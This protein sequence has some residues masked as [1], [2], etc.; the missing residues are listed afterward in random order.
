MVPASADILTP[1]SRIVAIV[2]PSP[3]PAASPPFGGAGFPSATPTPK[4]Y[5]VVRGGRLQLSLTGSLSLGTQASSQT[6]Y[7]GTP[8]FTPTPNASGSPSPFIGTATTSN[9]AQSQGSLGM[10][11]DISRR[12]ATTSTDLRVPFAVSTN[13]RSLIGGTQLL[14]STPRYALGYGAQSTSLFGQL[15]AGS[16]LRSLYAI[17][18]TRNGDVTMYGGPSLGANGEELPLKGLRWRQ[19]AGP[20]LFEAGLVNGDGPQT[21]KATTILGGVATSRGPLSF[22]GESAWQD[23][24][25]GDEDVSGL[26]Y[27]LRADDGSM[28]SY[29]TLITRRI[30]PG[31][32]NFGVGENFGDNYWDVN[33][34]RAGSSQNFTADTSSE[35]VLDGVGFAS[36]L[37][38]SSLGYSGPFRFGSYSLT[39]QSQRTSGDGAYPLWLGSATTQVSASVGRGF[40]LL[41]NQLNRQTTTGTAGAQ[42]L[43]GYSGSYQQPFGNFEVGG[44]YTAYRLVN[45]VTGSGTTAT[46]GINISRQFRKSAYALTESWGHNLGS[47]TNALVRN[48]QFTV[49]RTISPVITIQAAYTLQQLNDRISPASNGRSHSFSIQLNAPFGYGNGFVSGR[50]D[51]KLPATIVGRVISDASSAGYSPFATSGVGNVVVVLDDKLIQR[52]DVTGGFQFAF[53]T[54][55]QHQ[56]RVESASLPRGLT[57]DI[58]VNTVQV[59][60]GQTAQMTFLVGNFGGISGHIYGRDSSGVIVPLPNVLLRVDGGAYSQTDASGAYGFGR[61]RP[62]KHTIAIIDSSVPAFAEFDAT[63]EKAQVDVKNGNYTVVDFTA[64]PLGSISG[65]ILFAHDMGKDAG[66]PVDN[67]YVVAEPGEHAAIIE[68]D[69]SF[70]IDDLPPG[71]Y[72]VSVDPETIPD[73]LGAAPESF[74]V[75]L[76]SKEHYQGAAFLVG[77]SEKKV[78]FSFVA[79]GSGDNASAPK[80]HVSEGRLPPRGSATISVD[81]PKEAGPVKAHAFDQIVDLT[82]DDRRKAWIGDLTVPTNVKAADYDVTASTAAGTQPQSASLTVDPKMP[83]AILQTDPPNPQPGQYVRVRA[84]FLVDVAPGDRIE[85]ADGQTTVLGRAVS[86]R[87]FTFNLRV[88]LRPLHGVLLTKVARLPISLM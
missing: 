61:L 4:P 77:H 87:V 41:T 18:P 75:D 31:F 82:Y 1:L 72:T 12:T 71:T 53:V 56:V 40:L 7:N 51:A 76:G 47:S 17:V 9:L 20:V 81:A 80:V 55:G 44:N 6:L 39:V 28:Q 48:S 70:T 32:V 78:V 29:L 64:E 50:A 21:G 2:I 68:N 86:G 88:S 38:Q 52:T 11:A 24:K 37:R 23:R 27:Q 54:P 36:F 79:G 84:R 57:V 63:K 60:G 85:W 33:Y 45:S 8:E 16:T 15:P 46:E 69:G 35:R 58:P 34:R 14:F 65:S 3:S 30:A 59:E 49:S 25:G 83:L 74:S 26:S 73:G 43:V 66:T 42:A 19:D 67:A 5:Q 22:I 10:Y 13:A 62:G